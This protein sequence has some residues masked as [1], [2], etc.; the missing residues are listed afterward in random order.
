MNNYFRYAPRLLQTKAVNIQE[1]CRVKV[2]T[3]SGMG[4][5]GLKRMSP[6]P[7]WRRSCSSEYRHC[8]PSYAV[9]VGEGR[10]RRVV[11]VSFAE[12]L[13][14]GAQPIETRCAGCGGRV[15]TSVQPWR[16]H[17]P[18]YARNGA[19]ERCAGAILC[20]EPYPER[21]HRNYR[22]LCPDCGNVLGLGINSARP[23]ATEGTLSA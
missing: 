10:R 5:K 8:E 18:T 19:A 16:C 15:R 12:P 6:H 9:V 20:S 2:P 23:Q 21:A 3:K 13:V 14:L 17:T 11:E 7:Q 22:H 4:T 1:D